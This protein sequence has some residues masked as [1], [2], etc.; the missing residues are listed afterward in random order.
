MGKIVKFCSTC[1]EG[2]AEKFSFCPNCA[3]EL[4]AFEMKPVAEKAAEKAAEEADVPKPAANIKRTVLEPIVD[5]NAVD[6]E[7][8]ADDPLS[9]SAEDPLS[10]SAEDTVFEPVDLLADT[11]NSFE[12]VA[13]EIE[14]ELPEDPLEEPPVFES[15]AAVSFDASVDDASPTENKEEEVAADEFETVAAFTAPETEVEFETAAD[16]E[17]SAAAPYEPAAGNDEGFAVTVISERNGSVRNGLLLGA[18]ALIACGFMSMMIFSLFNNLDKIPALDQDPN[19]L[20]YLNDTPMALEEE[21]EEEKEGEEAGGGGGGGK[22]E[23][24]PVPKGVRPIML[25]EPDPNFPP[26]TRAVRM[27]D[28]ELA[29]TRAVQGPINETKRPEGRTGDPGGLGDDLSDG[30]GTG[31]GYGTGKGKGAGPGKGGGFGPGSN[32]GMGGGNSGGIGRGDG[33]G[34]RPRTRPASPPKPKGPSSPMRILSKP[35]PAYTE[36]AR[37]VGLTGT[38]RLKV[39]FNANG[40]IGSIR[41]LK[42]LGHGLTEKAIAAARS[43]RFKPQLQNGRPVGVSKTL[44]YNFSIY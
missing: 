5:K 6:S 14:I 18:F 24:K 1:E 23:S 4:S 37:K 27:T 19:L 10:V 36:A 13:E 17:M 29:V 44:V 35:K 11:T 8:K 32:G 34:G 7:V 2:F 28:P 9:V 26:T 3:H 33:N 25:K 16:Y 12:Q 43:I 40:T 21:K 31:G 39:T 38:V 30:P 22:E 15:P 41:P 20:A 42:G